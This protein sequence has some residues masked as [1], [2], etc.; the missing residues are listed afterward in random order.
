MRTGP[1]V[2]S[3]VS[4]ITRRASESRGVVATRDDQESV[5]FRRIRG[6]GDKAR[7][8]NYHVRDCVRHI[9][10]SGGDVNVQDSPGTPRC[11]AA[12]PEGVVIWLGGVAV[13]VAGHLGRPHR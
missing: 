5:R 7:L 3:R 11:G 6:A 10:D 1:A 4:R 9:C 8:S 13:V 2:I 12:G